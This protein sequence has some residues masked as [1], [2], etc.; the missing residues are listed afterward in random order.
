MRAP[1][2]VPAP[3]VLLVLAIADARFPGPAIG[4]FAAQTP[5]TADRLALVLGD[6]AADLVDAAV[7]GDAGAGAWR[8][9]PPCP[10]HAGLAG[11]RALHAPPPP[12]DFP[13]FLPPPP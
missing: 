9:V 8:F 2:L 3:L 4:D 5:P 12:P 13:L 11:P 10:R 6:P 1:N 7:P